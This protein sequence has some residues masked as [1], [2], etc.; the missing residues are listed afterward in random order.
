MQYSFDIVLGD[1]DYLAFNRFH[2]LKSP[3]GKKQLRSFRLCL[4]LFGV[5]FVAFF[6]MFM[7]AEDKWFLS[8]VTAVVIALFEIFA[9]RWLLFFLKK[10]IKRMKKTGTLGYSPA[11]RL[12]FGEDTMK[13]ITP[14]AMSEQKYSAI[15]RVS[16]VEERAVYLHPNAALAFLLPYDAFASHTEYLEFLA[17]LQTKIDKID[18]YVM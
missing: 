10:Q 3:Y 13:E 15:E 11:S 1:E 18:Y 4:A 17:F 6:L 2:L 8:A 16:V 5:V 12:E 7:P 9:S 14:D